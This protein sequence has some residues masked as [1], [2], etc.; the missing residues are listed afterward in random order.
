MESGIRYF[1]RDNTQ[2]KRIILSQAYRGYCCVERNFETLAIP[3]GFISRKKSWKIL[4]NNRL[5]NQNIYDNYFEFKK[6]YNFHKSNYFKHILNHRNKLN[7]II[8]H[9]AALYWRLWKF[10][11]IK[12]LGPT[13][14]QGR[15]RVK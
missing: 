9:M 5:N 3:Q 2:Y 14:Q 7:S 15:C 1:K 6:K 12:D 13:S 4:L 8:H 11:T 10:L